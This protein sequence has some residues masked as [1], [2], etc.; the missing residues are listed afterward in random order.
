MIG[1]STLGFVVPNTFFV[2]IPVKAKISE[3]TLGSLGWKDLL[4]RDG[5]KSCSGSQGDDF[6]TK[7]HTIL[8]QGRKR[9]K[10]AAFP[11]AASGNHLRLLHWSWASC[12]CLYNKY[13]PQ[14]SLLITCY[15][16]PIFTVKSSAT[17]QLR[18]ARSL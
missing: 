8:S 14:N 13:D 15:I 9:G 3:I 6:L 17:I 10:F 4:D 16:P 11:K 5:E 2:I 7:V 18:A 12:I 1:L